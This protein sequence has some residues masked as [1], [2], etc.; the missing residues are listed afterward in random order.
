MSECIFA[1]SV[2]QLAGTIEAD[3]T[4]QKIPTWDG[5]SAVNSS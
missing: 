3:A 5:Q 1:F 2:S 4:S